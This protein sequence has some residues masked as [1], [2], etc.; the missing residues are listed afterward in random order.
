M[1]NM[2]D[3]FIE[4]KLTP[5]GKY[6]WSIKL[7]FKNLSAYPMYVMKS[8]ENF[9]IKAEQKVIYTNEPSQVTEIEWV[10]PL[11][12][13]LKKIDDELKNTFPKNAGELPDSKSSYKGFDDDF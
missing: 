3:S 5:K 4:L 10:K 6:Y 11:V 8:G 12:A 2:T 9:E 13:Q 1:E 7:G